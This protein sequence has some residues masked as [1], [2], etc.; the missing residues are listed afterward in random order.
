VQRTGP[1]AAAASVRQHP[2]RDADQPAELDAALEGELAPPGD[3]IRL[4]DGVVGVLPRRH[5]SGIGDNA[6]VGLR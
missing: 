6:R 1:P 2:V 3:R 5:R 4:G